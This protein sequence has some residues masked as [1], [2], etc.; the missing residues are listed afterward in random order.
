MNRWI[1]VVLL[2]FSLMGTA[3]WVAPALAQTSPSATPPREFQVEDGRF[4]ALSPDGTAFAAAIRLTALC[5]YSSETLEELSCGSLEQLDAGLRLEDVVWSPDSTRLAFGEQ[6]FR[7]GQ[8]GDLWVMDAQTGVV[9]N[10]TDD[11]FEGS[12]LSLGNDTAAE[13]TFYLDVVPAWTPD[14]QYITFSRSGFVNGERTGNDIAQVPA[15]GGEVEILA[16]VPNAEVG[17][18]YFGAG[19][20]PAG[21]IYYFSLTH[22][23]SG[24]PDSGIWT[25]DAG[26][27]EIAPLAIGPDPE[28]GALAVLQ[29]SPAGDQL[30]AWYPQIFGQFD[31]EGG[32]LRLVDVASGALSEPAYPPS[33]R[34]V[35]A[36]TNCG[37]ILSRRPSVA[38]A[39]A[40]ERNRRALGERS[41]H[42]RPNPA[43]GWARGCRGRVWA[44]AGLGR[45]RQRCL[46]QRERGGISDR[47]CRNRNGHHC[48]SPIRSPHRLPVAFPLGVRCAASSCRKD[49]RSACR[50]MAVIWPRRS[51]PTDPFASTKSQ[52]WPR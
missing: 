5:V 30:L 6:G 36:G 26:T 29:V 31:V 21:E 7:I 12:M 44:Y 9:T 3:G 14:S 28:F 24:D 51:C 39:D 32:L 11:G 27:G 35:P 37:D 10:L 16:T 19:W 33:A 20:D 8:D 1:S 40:R 15:A 45:Q 2:V 52:P 42:R 41:G 38:H 49:A 23:N 17:A 50:P 48:Q 18:L 46:R 47:D 25:F 43:A 22:M 4:I 13:P 34:G